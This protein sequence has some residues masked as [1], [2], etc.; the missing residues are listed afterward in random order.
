MLN[1]SMLSLFL[2][3]L[4]SKLFRFPVDASDLSWWWVTAPIWSYLIFQII[5]YGFKSITRKR[6]SKRFELDARSRWQQRVDE[7]QKKSK[8]PIQFRK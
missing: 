4:L 6:K 7:I 3:L 2:A 8:P 5:C 1:A